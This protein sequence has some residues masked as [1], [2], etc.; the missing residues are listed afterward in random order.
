MPTTDRHLFVIFGATGDLTRRKLLPA[1]YHLM[2]E[3]GVAEKCYVLGVALEDWS[4]EQFRTHA[5]E[6]LAEAFSEEELRTWCDRNLFYQSLGADASRYAELR[7]RIEAIEAEHELPGNRAYYLSL[8]PPAYGPTIASLGDVG[9]NTSGGWT[10]VVI[11]KPFGK[12]LASAQELNALVHQHFDETQVYR[13]DH[14]LGKETAQNLLAFRFGNA[15]FESAWNR[16][17]V[18]RVEI[19]VA[20]SLGVEARAG[21]YDDAGHLRDMVQNHLTQ[22]FTLMAM[23]PPSSFDADAI[24]DE[25]VKV[26][27]STRPID[28][29]Q[30]QLGQ[31][32]AGELDG[33][34]MPGYRQEEGVP[35]DSTT[36]TFVSLPLY[37][38][39][40]RWQG[41][42]FVLRT[43]KRLPRKLTQIAVHFR[44]APISLFQND[45]TN[46]AGCDVNP[47]VLV[48]TLQPNEGFDLRFE[49]KT[50]GEAVQLATEE[51]SFR[52]KEAFSAIPDA[53]ETLLRDIIQGDQTLF[54]RA[55]E[56]E[57]SWRLYTPVLDAALEPVPYPAGAWG[58]D[59]S[60]A[61]PV[62]E[63]QP[64]V[65]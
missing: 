35:E 8:P 18:E 36:E 21:Y 52:Y 41:V 15:L 1:L 16:D 48:I 11:E 56:V 37:I 14:Y 59:T 31:Y 23:E 40:W 44:C 19:T 4:T 34:P 45:A 49:V 61:A 9:L 33:V 5:R 30:V 55:D 50:P 57:H 38:D 24:R 6:A 27:R 58:P 46:G 10:R 39:N 22:L 13:I 29:A 51:L 42:P 60:R 64:Q 62:R 26:L 17:R 53:Y 28:T 25:K 65:A 3:Q 12:D 2:Q 47:N 32:A 20:E 43:G 7:R 63:A 54:V